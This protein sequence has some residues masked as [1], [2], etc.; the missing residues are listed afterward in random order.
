MGCEEACIEAESTSAATE[1]VAVSPHGRAVAM[2]SKAR[3]VKLWGVNTV[4]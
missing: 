3:R 1:S 2:G 4:C